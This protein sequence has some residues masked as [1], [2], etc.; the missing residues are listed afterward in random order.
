MHFGIRELSTSATWI[1][2]QKNSFDFFSCLIYVNEKDYDE[3]NRCF[4]L[5]KFHETVVYYIPRRTVTY[6]KIYDF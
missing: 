1:R 6:L 4:Y 5:G 3:K 2:P